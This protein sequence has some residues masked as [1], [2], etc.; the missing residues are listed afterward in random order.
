MTV[1]PQAGDPPSV[2]EDQQIEMFDKHRERSRPKFRPKRYIPVTSCNWREA[3][4]KYRVRV[5]NRENEQLLIEIEVFQKQLALLKRVY[6]TI[7]QRPKTILERLEKQIQEA[8][9]LLIEDA[10]DDFE[11]FEGPPTVER[12]EKQIQEAQSLK[13]KK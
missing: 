7:R 2:S 11:G 8:Q 4:R 1:P 3:L 6:R 10:L 12:L 9:S 5:L 13:S